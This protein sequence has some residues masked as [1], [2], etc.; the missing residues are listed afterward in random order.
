M[1]DLGM[2]TPG[3]VLRRPH[4]VNGPVTISSRGNPGPIPR[5]N[6]DLDDLKN[7]GLIPYFQVLE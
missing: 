2:G 7:F 1:V 3:V 6:I 5:E 4:G